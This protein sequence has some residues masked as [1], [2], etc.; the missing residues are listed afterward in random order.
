MAKRQKLPGAGKPGRKRGTTGLLGRIFIVLLSI[1]L[2]MAI[3]IG[4][5]AA[6]LYGLFG[7]VTLN[8]AEDTFGVSFGDALLEED[9]RLRDLTVLGMFMEFAEVSGKLSEFTAESLLSEY[10]VKL[11]EVLKELV[12]DAVMQDVPLSE[13]LGPN[14]AHVLLEHVTF[15]NLLALAGDGLI[16]EAAYEK[17]KDRPASLVLDGDLAAIFEG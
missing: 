9:S 2:G 1:L 12:P 13:L 17:I 7:W 11:P 15:G 10:G 16:P 8:R 5:E 6:I 3:V 4:A 14:A